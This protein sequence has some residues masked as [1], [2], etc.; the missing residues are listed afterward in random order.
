M[1][2]SVEQLKKTSGQALAESTKPVEAVRHKN[3]RLQLVEKR[4][5]ADDMLASVGLNA[6]D[7]L[8][9]LPWRTAQNCVA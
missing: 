9:E 7:M 3:T 8:A 1:I 6:S 2:H 5:E 4:D